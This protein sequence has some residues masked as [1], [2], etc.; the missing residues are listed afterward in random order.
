MIYSVG[1]FLSRVGVS[2]SGGSKYVA[3]ETSADQEWN[4]SPRTSR[5]SGKGAEEGISGAIAPK[6]PEVSVLAPLEKL[7]ND[8]EQYL[9]QER[10]FATASDIC[11]MPIFRQFLREHCTGGCGS[12]SNLTAI[13]INKFVER[14]VNDRGP[15]SA[16]IMGSI[17]RS[18]LRYLRYRGEIACEL[19]KRRANREEVETIVAAKVPGSKRHQ[20]S[21][22]YLR[23]SHRTG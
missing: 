22:G 15:R 1:G 17:L 10:G 2:R 3:T 5:F 21:P 18:F 12:L 19:S 20:A 9:T 11:H 8:F 4:F 16:Q 7:E 13:A 23:S 6:P 14:R